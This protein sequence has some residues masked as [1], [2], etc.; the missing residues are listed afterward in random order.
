MQQALNSR[1]RN[2]HETARDI[3]DNSINSSGS[4]LKTENRKPKIDFGRAVSM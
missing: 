4:N 3:R 2:H 1:V